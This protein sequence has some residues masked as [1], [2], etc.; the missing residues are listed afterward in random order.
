MLK[1]GL[2]KI[3]A[4]LSESPDSFN[5]PSRLCLPYSTQLMM[6]GAW[7]LS[8]TERAN[9]HTLNNKD[10]RS[11]SNAPHGCLNPLKSS[12]ENFSSSKK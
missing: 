5:N 4:D 2:F 3:L 12:N 8:A 9:K 11:T 7:V 6:S 10:I 1:K